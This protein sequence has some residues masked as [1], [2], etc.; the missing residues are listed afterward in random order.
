[1]RLKTA[2]I[3]QDVAEP[4]EIVLNEFELNAAGGCKWFETFAGDMQR[5]RVDVERNKS[6]AGLDAFQ[7]GSAVPAGAEC[8]IDD[9]VSGFEQ[10]VFE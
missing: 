6:S 4:A 5:L 10:K 3:A 8:T 7:N 9:G 1:M 2:A